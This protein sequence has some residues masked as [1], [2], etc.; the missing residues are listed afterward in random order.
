MFKVYFTQILVLVFVTQVALAQNTITLSSDQV[1]QYYY[2]PSAG[3]M[4]I[5]T[6]KHGRGDA[7]FDLY[8][9]RNEARTSQLA[10]SEVSGKGTELIVL[11]AVNYERCVYISVEHYEGSSATYYLYAQEVNFWGELGEAVAISALECWFFG[12]PGQSNLSLDE[13]GDIIFTALEESV[14]RGESRN[15]VLNN[16]R[17]R[18]SSQIGGGFWGTL[19]LTYVTELV[20]EVYRYY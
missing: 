1:D 8:V 17:H 15:T 14:A 11:D 4:P 16:M 2:C 18:L 20:K 9:Y 3:N 7:D 19:A 12:C 10:S 5:F 13:V 6:L